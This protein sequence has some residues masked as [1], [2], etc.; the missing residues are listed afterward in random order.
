MFIST[1]GFKKAEGCRQLIPSLSANVV[2]KLQRY[3]HKH[4]IPLCGSRKKGSIPKAK[5][6]SIVAVKGEAREYTSS[7]KRQQTQQKTF[8]KFFVIKVITLA[9]RVLTNGM[10]FMMAPSCILRLACACFCDL[11][12][13]STTM[14]LTLLSAFPYM[15]TVYQ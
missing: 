10:G 12:G 4:S 2:Q 3:L 6:D 9:G 14:C 7:Y 15:P 1:E 13:V 11:H 5:N 8:W